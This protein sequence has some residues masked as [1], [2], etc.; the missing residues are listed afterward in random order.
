MPRVWQIRRAPYKSDV[1]AIAVDVGWIDRR[2]YSVLS[3]FGQWLLLFCILEKTEL[4][5][6]TNTSFLLE[7]QFA[8]VIISFP[9]GHDSIRAEVSAQLC[10]ERTWT[11]QHNQGQTSST[12]NYWDPVLSDSLAVSSYGAWLF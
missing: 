10:R 5:T 1:A 12:V 2:T 11:T 9:L 8:W 3:P 6:D 4:V 7:R